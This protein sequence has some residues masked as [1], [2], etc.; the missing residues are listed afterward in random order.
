MPQ[1]RSPVQTLAPLSYH[2]AYTLIS[3]V[4]NAGGSLRQRLNLVDEIYGDICARM[5][6]K[7]K[8]RKELKNAD[9]RADLD[10]RLQAIGEAIQF[11][12]LNYEPA[13]DLNIFTYGKAGAFES[14]I[15]EILRTEKMFIERWGLLTKDDFQAL[16]WSSP[17]GMGTMP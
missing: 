8:E 3:T 7:R 15:S 4:I 11:L 9:N 16:P 10:I 5:E 2:M 17:G 12:R 1:A 14:A 13:L 6:S